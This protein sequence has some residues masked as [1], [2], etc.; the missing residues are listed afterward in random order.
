MLAQKFAQIGTVQYTKVKTKYG[1]HMVKDKKTF[2]KMFRKNLRMLKY[3]FM[4]EERIVIWIEGLKHEI[5][6]D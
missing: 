1:K 4:M 6:M 2:I 3:Y 5:N